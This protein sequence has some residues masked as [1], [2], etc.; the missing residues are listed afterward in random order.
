MSAQRLPDWTARLAKV[1]VE[2][3]RVPFAWGSN[4]CVAF[5]ADCVAAMHG[6]DSMAEFRTE[7]RCARQAQQQLAEGGG[8]DAGLA[9]AGLEEVPPAFAQVGDLVLLRLGPRRRVLGVC[10]GLE[11]LS[12]A[13]RGLGQAPMANA[14]QAWRV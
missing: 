7:R 10:N 14:V 2:R 8:L 3:Q 13:R 12:P 1:V 9:R 6:K 4:D 5:A 11:A